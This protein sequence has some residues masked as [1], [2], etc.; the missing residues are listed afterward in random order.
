M[1]AGS[2]RQSK[3]EHNTGHEDAAPGNVKP[4]SIEEK[5]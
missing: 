1:E 2:V 3:A 5:L 4:D